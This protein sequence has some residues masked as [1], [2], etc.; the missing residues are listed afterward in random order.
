[1]LFRSSSALTNRRLRSSLHNCEDK[2]GC[3]THVHSRSTERKPQHEVADVVF[4]PFLLLLAN[5]RGIICLP[6]RDMVA[7][8][9]KVFVADPFHDSLGFLEC[10]VPCVAGLDLSEDAKTVQSGRLKLLDSDI[11][12]WWFIIALGS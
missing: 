6:I 9:R 8:E 10:P 12:Y 7:T 2:P 4:P 3:H 5:Q 11:L 1:M